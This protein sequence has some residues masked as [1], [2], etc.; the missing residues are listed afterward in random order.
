M[1]RPP[2]PL[3]PG[4]AAPV[5][6]QALLVLAHVRRRTY[7]DSAY[8]VRI[9]TTTVFRYIRDA[10]R[11]GSDGEETRHTPFAL[12]RRQTAAPSIPGRGGCV[13]PGGRAATTV[14]RRWR[15]PIAELDVGGDL[16]YGSVGDPEGEPVMHLIAGPEPP[17]QFARGTEVF[18]GE[19]G[20]AGAGSEGDRS[21]V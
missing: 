16:A 18:T 11:A 2:E 13:A 12:T 3:N 5:C 14:R 8:G 1:L 21:Q 17:S 4:Q 7:I 9:G 19:V 10:L 15:R 6:E 20:D